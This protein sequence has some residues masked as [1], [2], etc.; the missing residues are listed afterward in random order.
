MEPGQ[1]LERR[2]GGPRARAEA[3]TVC[4]YCGTGRA[5]AESRCESCGATRTEER[6]NTVNRDTAGDL[7]D[8]HQAERLRKRGE[9]AATLWRLERARLRRERARQLRG[10]LRV[11]LGVL[12]TLA[13][14]AAIWATVVVSIARAQAA[15]LPGQPTAR[16]K[17]DVWTASLTGALRAVPVKLGDGLLAEPVAGFH[18]GSHSRGWERSAILSACSG[19]LAGLEGKPDHPTRLGTCLEVGERARAEAVP[20]SLIL[21]LA[22]REA[23]FVRLPSEGRSVR[24]PLQVSPRWHCPGRK[25]DGCDLVLEGVRAA[26]RLVA[27][28]GCV[29]GIAQYNGGP[30]WRTRKPE[31]GPWAEGVCRQARRLREQLTSGMGEYRSK[32]RARAAVK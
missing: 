5:E 29:A 9:A 15:P 6:P 22:W 7:D 12:L 18:V 17:D 2:E 27:K 28:F 3:A 24:G 16:W 26:G 21:A 23:K 30:G 8:Y 31:S 13:V 25:A 4:V 10:W 20:V 32:L 14:L 1:L 11:A 19:L